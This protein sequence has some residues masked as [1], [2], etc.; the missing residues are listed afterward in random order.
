MNNRELYKALDIPR[1]VVE[2]LNKY[3]DTRIFNMNNKIKS[4][5]CDREK[6][7]EAV[8]SIQEQL[9]EDADGIKILWEELNLVCESYDR[10]VQMGIPYE[11]F[12][13][14]MKF[15][16]RFLEEHKRTYGIYKYTWA[17]WYPRQISLNEFRI[18]ALEYEFIDGDNREIYIHI[19]SDADFSRES[20]QRSIKEFFS[21]RK[22]YFEAWDTVP[23]SC[24]SWLLSPALKEM[25]DSDSN[26]IGFQNLFKLE[27]V[28]YDNI[29]YLGW[30]YPGYDTADNNLPENTRLQRKMKEYILSGNKVGSAKGYLIN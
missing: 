17:W 16:T 27:R 24:D 25:L 9:G 8:K 15:C 3:E 30:V 21:F 26:I 1:E 12:V 18:G 7:D 14:T 22:K 6:W 11:I 2:E 5:I 10:Y 28:D 4:D 19:P 20:V 23:L 13:D 29:W